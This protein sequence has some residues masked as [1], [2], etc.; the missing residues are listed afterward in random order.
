VTRAPIAAALVL[1]AAACKKPS[2]PPQE[3][4]PPSVSVSPPTTVPPAA[5]EGVAPVSDFADAALPEGQ[6]PYEQAR[7]YAAN[8]QLWLARLVL[9]KKALG[10]DGTKQELELLA[11][12]CHEQGDE[13]CVMQCSKKLGKKLKFDGGAPRPKIDP[14]EHEEPATDLARARD[15]TLKG[16]YTEARGILE[17]KLLDGKASKAEIRLLRTVCKNQGDRMCIALCDAK[18]K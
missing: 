7:A 6:T 1:V 9:E 15:L 12:I 14:G 2:P 10:A 8:G 17:P 4:P 3:E 5:V 16:Q 18:L 13:A 11:S